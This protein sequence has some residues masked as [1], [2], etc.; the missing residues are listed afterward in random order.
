MDGKLLSLAKKKLSIEVSFKSSSPVSLTTN[1]ELY[2]EY[3][4]KI[5]IPISVTAE[6]CALTTFPYLETFSHGE[7][8]RDKDHRLK[9]QINQNLNP[10]IRKTASEGCSV[11]SGNF[12]KKWCSFE[13]NLQFENFPESLIESKG[14]LFY[15]LV[16]RMSNG[17]TGL[18]KPAFDSEDKISRVK[19]LHHYYATAIDILQSE[20]AFLNHIRPEHL[21]NVGD[22]LIFVMQKNIALEEEEFDDISR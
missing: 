14:E 7:V 12:I 2:D 16:H 13:L 11:I 8:V 4:E 10:P 5:E 9:L 3:G 21:L 19:E 15:Q 18:K 17:K 20:G 22:Y 1:L 6:N